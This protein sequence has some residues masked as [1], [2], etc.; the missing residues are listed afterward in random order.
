VH[1]AFRLG[2]WGMYP[3]TFFGLVLLV[4]A[5][6]YMRNPA[7]R[8]LLVLR[9]LEVL[10]SLAAILGFVTGV[11]RAFINVPDNKPHYAVIGAGESLINV[12]LGLVILI[13]ARIIITA[14]AARGTDSAAELLDP[15]R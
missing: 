5:M 15:Q 7:R 14:G 11:I 4:A 1:D 6:Q 12:G 10:V 13:L 9:H 3:T 2:G 8:R